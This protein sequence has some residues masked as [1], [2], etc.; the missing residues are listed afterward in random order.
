MVFR[1][2]R[3]AVAFRKRPAVVVTPPVTT[4]GGTSNAFFPTGPGGGSVGDIQIILAGQSGSVFFADDY[5][6]TYK[7]LWR[8]CDG[9]R[10]LTGLTQAQSQEYAQWQGDGPA[11][12]FSD[13]YLYNFDTGGPAK[14]LEPVGANL[15][16]PT[17]W[18]NTNIMNRF[19][20]YCAEKQGLIAANRP[21]FLLYMHNEYVSKLNGA[22]AAIYEQAFL[23][24]VR[25]YRAAMSTRSKAL[26]PVF[27]CNTAYD[28]GVNGDTM[29]IIRDAYRN[30]ALNAAN[31]IFIGHGGA[32]D[33]DDRNS[34]NSHADTASLDRYARRMTVNTARWL[35]DNGYTIGRDLSFLP[36]LGPTITSVARVSGNTS[37]LD[38]GITHDGI[39]TDMVAPTGTPNYE[40]FEVRDN[41]ARVDVTG[42]TRL[43]ATTLRATMASAISGNGTVTLDYGARTPFFGIGSQWTDNFHLV[44]KPAVFNAVADMA[45]VRMILNRYGGVVTLGTSNAPGGGGGTNNPNPVVDPATQTI[46]I[47]PENPGTRDA[48]P[49]TLTI[50]S[51]NLT[52]VSWTRIG[53]APNYTFLGGA[54]DQIDG[55]TDVTTTGSVPI[56]PNWTQ[57]GQRVK[58]WPTGNIQAYRDTLPVTI[59]AAATVP[60]APG[61]DRAA[62]HDFVKDL[63]LG[64]NLERMNT[65]FVTTSW[66][67][68]IVASGQTHMRLFVYANADL[69]FPSNDQLAGHMNAIKAIQAAGLK[70]MLELQDVTSIGAMNNAGTLPYLLRACDLINTQG[71]D[72][73]RFAVGHS[74]E[75]ANAGNDTFNYVNN[76]CLDQMR[77]RLQANTLLTQS[78]GNW[79]HPD[80]LTDGT[81]QLGSDKRRI[82]CWHYYEWDYA[83][84]AAFAS[85]KNQVKA[86]ADENGVEFCNAEF[87]KFDPS[88]VDTSYSV[89]PDVINAYARGAG[90]GGT[91]WTFTRG[92]GWRLNVGQSGS[93]SDNLMRSEVKAA[94]TTENAWIKAQ[95]GFGT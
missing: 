9:V 2:G 48:G 30:V 22:A 70:V 68:D 25:R 56:E 73:T 72:L 1:P 69:G 14:W 15:S 84:Q 89:Y 19:L 78:S 66:L 21:V 13:T 61:T 26:T 86:W 16:D 83:N 90:G 88:F 55:W 47:S 50:T 33:A 27:V 38:F 49:Q 35:Y 53:P 74:N 76:Y 44:T 51:T 64:T 92:T 40:N 4:P 23:E 5:E 94:F 41:G 95:S 17:T 81:M 65:D 62:A 79:G 12:L 63:A 57:T 42:L 58:Y 7:P 36:R 52:S 8:Y 87:G 75:L 91:M 18:A 45:N 82:Y 71:F 54:T 11:S 29:R 59:N 80:T 39:A 28:S 24:F 77:A 10:A 60:A 46:S 31:N 43:N 32:D 67:N 20:A 34:D 93:A 6:T 85:R 37:A 3:P